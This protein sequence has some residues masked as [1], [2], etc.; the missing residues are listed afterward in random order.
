MAML[1]RGDR[2]LDAVIHIREKVGVPLLVR[3]P[4]L[5]GQIEDER[6]RSRVVKRV[7]DVEGKYVCRKEGRTIGI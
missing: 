6:K 5:S 4:P 7:C 2:A 3:L 1:T